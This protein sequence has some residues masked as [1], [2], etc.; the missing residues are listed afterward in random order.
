MTLAELTPG[1]SG[2]IASVTGEPAL[3][4]RLYELGLC[5]GDEV[6]VLAVAPLGDP[7]GVRGGGPRLSLRK[8]D[9]HGVIL[10]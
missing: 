2:R 8:S 10:E 9:A 3:V 1:Q 6:E 4:Q 7:I 5:D